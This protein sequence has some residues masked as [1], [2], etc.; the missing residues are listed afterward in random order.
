[1]ETFLTIFAAVAILYLGVV[2]IMLVVVAMSVGDNLTSESYSHY[3]S[4]EKCIKRGREACVV[5]LLWPFFATRWCA[6][7]ILEWSFFTGLWAL[8]RGK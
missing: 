4:R 5:V 3:I 7:S 2:L 6:S 8:I 1:M